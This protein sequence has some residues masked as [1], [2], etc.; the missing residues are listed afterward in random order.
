MA[1]NT[2]LKLQVFVSSTYS[3]LKQERQAAVQAILKVGHIPAGME[4]FSAGNESQMKVIRQWI[5]DS[6][7]FLLILGGRYGSIEPDSGKSYTHLEHEYAIQQGKPSFA[8][9]ITDECLNEKV[10]NDGRD[11]IETRNS[12]QFDRFKEEVLNRSMVQFWSDE[13]DIK[14]A[15]LEALPEIERDYDLTG[16]VRDDSTVDTAP[17]AEELARLGKENSELRQQITI[18][19]SDQNSNSLSFDRLREL[20]EQESSDL[21]A[22]LL[23]VRDELLSDGTY[24]S[25]WKT[26]SKAFEGLISY[27]IVKIDRSRGYNF[28]K[29]ALTQKGQ[30]FLLY[31]MSEL[32]LKLN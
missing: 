28:H 21:F 23:A 27:G 16:W 13:K 1:R 26:K 29:Y 20:L 32:D 17:L 12:A 22:F 15:I 11:V 2:E 8:V 10:H 9:V 14:L 30:D 24:K 5:D 19:S 18:L 25:T 4:L 7:V 31:H 3:D 6:D